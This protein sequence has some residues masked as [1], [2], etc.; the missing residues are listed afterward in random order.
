MWRG[1]AG[2]PLRF[3][4]NTNSY[5]GLGSGGYR[6]GMFSRPLPPHRGAFVA[7]RLPLLTAASMAALAAAGPALAGCAPGNG[8]PRDYLCTGVINDFTN[9]I[10]ART[11]TLNGA[12]ITGLFAMIPT[13]NGN[14][15]FSMDAASSITNT[16]GGGPHVNGTGLL[17]YTSNGS[18]DTNT[19]SGSGINGKITAPDGTALMAITSGAG[20]NINI[21]TGA[22]AVLT[23]KTGGLGARTDSNGAINLNI[24]GKI[25]SSEGYGIAAQ[26]VDG[27]V[28][29]KVDADVN[30]AGDGVDALTTGKGAINISGAGNITSSGGVGVNAEAAGG[31]NVSINLSGTITGAVAGIVAQSHGGD[32]TVNATGKVTGGDGII[33]STTGSGAVTVTTGGKVTATTGDGVAA[34]SENGWA[35][36]NV[37]AGGVTAASDGVVAMATGKGS[38]KVQ[39]HGDISGAT[40]Y[41]IAASTKSGSIEID[42]DAGKFVSGGIAGVIVQTQTGDATINNAGTIKGGGS[43]GAAVIIDVNK[44]SATLNNSGTIQ[45]DANGMAIGVASGAALIKNTGKIDGTIVSN[46]IATVVNDGTWNNAAGSYIDFLKNTGVINMGSDPTKTGLLVVTGDASFGPG[47]YYNARIT[48]TSSDTIY[49]GG[50]AT[51]DGGLVRISADQDGTYQRGSRYILLYAKGGLT[52]QFDGVISDMSKYTGILTYDAND[53]YLTVLLRDFRSFARTRN[54]WSVANGIYW[55]TAQMSGGLGGQMLLAL[56]Q[57]SDASVATS[58]TQLSGDGVVTGAANAALQTSHLFTSVLDDQQALWRDSAPRDQ[59][60]RRV[61]PFA[62][63]PTRADG[64]KW[65][66]SRQ[67]YAPAPVRNDGVQRWRV[68]A[69]GFGGRSSLAGDTVAGSADQKLNSYGGALGV[70]Y[71]MG[72]S[73]LLGMALGGSSSAFNAGNATGSAAGVHV[74][75]YTGFRVQSFYGTASVAYSNYANKT[76]RTVGAI[77]AVAGEQEEGRFTSEEVRTRLEIG[78]RI[79]S[80]NYAVTP[81]TAIEIAHLHTKPFIEQAAGGVGMFAL[82]F[83][84]QGVASTPTF[85]GLKAEGR[86]DLAG[87]ILTPWISL[88]WRHEWSTSRTQTASLVALPGASFVIIGASPARDAAQVKAGVNLAV[89]QQVAVF[90]SFEGEFGTKNPVYGGK[91]GVKVAW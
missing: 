37:G 82:G 81:F 87:A 5:R 48:S 30:A 21:T 67:T 80:D 50:K 76:L 12:T 11:L 29:I 52:G 90:A 31:G 84:S 70:D 1:K 24:A 91:G 79:A 38:V 19:P 6:R 57:A 25:V 42:L 56:N 47:S 71:Q 77:G 18:I 2:K 55:A 85:I 83:K 66:V 62:Y 8:G 36:V 73:M 23:G 69:S 39:A 45:A 32:V 27:T 49:V 46:G 3:S 78:R 44:G 17:L 9:N 74:G 28:N 40:G 58:L 75:G 54:Q 88:A 60:V 89:T 65:P 61:E 41:G 7:F 33:A 13:A 63:A 14:I 51:I 10:N 86:F 72:S 53:V 20:S 4:L 26:A 68:W 15:A 64:S 34:Q 43:K 22:T 35:V 16:V 59:I